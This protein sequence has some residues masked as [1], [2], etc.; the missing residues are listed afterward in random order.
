MAKIWDAV[1]TFILSCRMPGKPASPLIQTLLSPPFGIR[2]R[3]MPVILATPLRKY[4]LQG[5]LTF[6]D[7]ESVVDKIDSELIEAIVANPERYTIVYTEVGERQKAIVDGMCKVFE[8]DGVGELGER[9]VSLK[10]KVVT[11]WQALPPFARKTSGISENADLMRKNVFIPLANEPCDEKRIFFENLPKSIGFGDVINNS[12][13][14]LQN[15]IQDKVKPVKDEFESITIKLNDKILTSFSE[16]FGGKSNDNPIQVISQWHDKLGKK[17]DIIESGD[18]GKLLETCRKLK[19]KGDTSTLVD[20]VTQV[21]GSKPENWNDSNRIIELTGQLKT[22]K[23]NIE[24]Q[25]SPSDEPKFDKEYISINLV[26][27]GK[28]VSRRFK[29][30]ASIS[31]LGTSMANLINNAIGEIG[32]GL[33]EEEKFT[34]LTEILKEHLK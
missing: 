21:T 19:E 25:P 14:N 6:K 10:E 30:A 8:V 34:I 1:D 17:G 3:S 16:V 15:Q 22:I 11:W 32:K 7:R 4:I 28:E 18:A 2:R 12:F 26:I 33:P 24:E 31:Q 23:K 9:L 13:E 5:N 29:K 27:D 20:F